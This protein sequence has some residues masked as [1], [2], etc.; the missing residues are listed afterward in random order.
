MTR[1][2]VGAP[3]RTPAVARLGADNSVD[4]AILARRSR[5]ECCGAAVMLI[6]E[7]F[8]PDL[9]DLLLRTG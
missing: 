8:L 7:W 1:T 2:M 4:A 5:V 3:H 6:D 9:R